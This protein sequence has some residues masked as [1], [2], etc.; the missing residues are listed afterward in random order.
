MRYFK[1]SSR[2][3]SHITNRRKS[4]CRK[5]FFKCDILGY[6]RKS[7][8]LVLLHLDKIE[9]LIRVDFVDTLIMMVKGNANIDKQAYNKS[10][11]EYVMTV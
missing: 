4:V 11:I 1:E 9:W 3:W 6:D 7:T 2:K 8:V 5:S 10:V